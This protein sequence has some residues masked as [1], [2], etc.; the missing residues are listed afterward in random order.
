MRRLSATVFFA[1]STAAS[2]QNYEITSSTIDAGGSVNQ[3][4]AGFSLSSTIGQ[5]ESGPTLNSDSFSVAPGFW[6]GV[7]LTQPCLADVAAPFGVLNFFDVAT[8]IGLYNSNDFNADLAAPFG[9][10]NFFD[11]AAFIGLYNSGCP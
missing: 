11:V 5:T 3:T 8:F 10:L 4:S 9:S 7:A 6:N 2:A 1:A